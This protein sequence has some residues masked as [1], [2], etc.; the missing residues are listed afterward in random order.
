MA[1][2]G[3]DAIRAGRTLR[4]LTVALRRG[5]AGD[6]AYHL[7]LLAMRSHPSG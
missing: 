5:R 7:A 2:A 1:G 4:G 6:V 3:G